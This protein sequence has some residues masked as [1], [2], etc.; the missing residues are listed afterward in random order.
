MPANLGLVLPGAAGGGTAAG[1][2][3]SGVPD[4]ACPKLAI[5]IRRPLCPVAGWGVGPG[6]CFGAEASTPT[7][8]G[9]TPA[10]GATPSEDGPY[11][12]DVGFGGAPAEALGPPVRGAA[13]DEGAGLSGTSGDIGTPG[14]QMR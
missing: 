9:D 14:P 1:G 2:G 3:I 4:K 11:G 6:A 7:G 13:A 5:G 10:A 8:I 12:T